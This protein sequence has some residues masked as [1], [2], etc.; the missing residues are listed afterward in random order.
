MS[1]R[2]KKL[3]LF[4]GLAAFVL[5]NLF[6]VSRFRTFRD[7]VRQE[8]VVAEKSIATAEDRRAAYDER[9]DELE[10][11][12]SHRPE[13]K[14]KQNVPPELEKFAMDQ[15]KSASLTVKGEKILETIE[16]GFFNRAR[17]EFTVTG[18]ES[19]FYRWMETLRAPEQF[20]TVTFMRLQ[21]DQKDD[22]QIDAQVTVEQFFIPESAES[23]EEEAPPS[24]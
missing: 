23:A 20:R 14:T 5:V 24:E 11:M 17:V 21:P 7:K 6:G 13:P 4:F 1:D 16:E 22:T 8:L 18:S 12:A 3:V 10:W 19:S 2:E 9:A 15:A